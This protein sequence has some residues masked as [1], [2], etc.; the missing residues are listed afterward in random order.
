MS[1]PGYLGFFKATL[2]Q[3][4]ALDVVACQSGMLYTICGVVTAAMC[5]AMSTSN[6]SLLLSNQRGSIKFEHQLPVFT[7]PLLPRWRYL[8]I[9]IC[10]CK[11]EKCFSGFLIPSGLYRIQM[12][13]GDVI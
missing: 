1:P 13:K 5:T 12:E 4:R 9:F 7:A 2:L 6:V 3:A 11:P 8:E 10:E